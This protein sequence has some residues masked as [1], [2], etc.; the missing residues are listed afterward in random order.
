MKNIVRR[1]LNI[2]EAAAVDQHPQ[3]HIQIQQDCLRNQQH[4][5]FTRHIQPNH[6]RQIRTATWNKFQK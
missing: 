4:Q 6:R 1:W 5:N 3:H 2:P